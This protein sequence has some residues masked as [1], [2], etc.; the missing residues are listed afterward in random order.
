M[1]RR[2]RRPDRVSLPPGRP[3]GRG[4]AWS[5]A[6][7]WDN[8]GNLQ[9]LTYPD[10]STV[11]TYQYDPLN[12]TTKALIGAASYGALTY[13]SLG[14]RQTLTFKDGSSQTWNYDNADR[15][16]S[17]AHAF[18]NRITDNVTFTYSYD[19]SGLDASK[20]LD[21]TAYAYSPSAATIAYGTPN[22]LNQYPSVNSYA[23]SYWPEGG[24]KQTDTFQANYNE[25]NK[26]ALTFITPTPG[27]VDPNNFDIQGTDALDHVYFHYRQTTAG[28]TYPFIYHSTDG[29]RPETILEWQCL[30]TAPNAPVCTGTGTGVR[31]YILGPDPDERWSFL[32][33]NG[34]IDSPHTDRQGTLIAMS[35]NAQ[36]VGKYAYDAYGQ[37]SSSASDVGPGV[38]SYLYRYT[39]QRLDPNTGLYDYKAREYSPG[40]GRFLQPDPIGQQDD[41]NLYAY[42]KDDPVDHAD[43]SGTAVDAVFYQDAGLVI[44]TDSFTGETRYASAFSGG[45]LMG[46]PI[47]AGNYAILAG[48][49]DNHYRLERYDNHFG[50]DATPEGRSLLRFH[51][52]G[53]ISLG[54]ITCHP[55]KGGDGIGTMLEGT[56]KSKSTVEYHGYNPFHGRTES[57]TNFGTMRVVEHSNYHFNQKTHEVTRTV[58]QLGSRIP[59]EKHVCSVGSDGKCH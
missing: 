9:T 18:P 13:D 53:S 7:G 33:S 22:A 45:G 59:R 28:Q 4:G 21:N 46:A 42:V 56:T 1:V 5:A 24:L 27:T 47:P 39:G 30:Q 49:D 25:L 37:N 29:L 3:T 16:T 12:R 44:A 19:P 20:T 8:A 36:A 2:G 43:P 51:P 57:L 52:H 35:N 10:G 40:L 31:R 50:D 34:T 32:D 38:A 6:Y 58:M 15:V 54:C 14:R 23:Y 55:G 17:I 26:A 41:P 11:V 48:K